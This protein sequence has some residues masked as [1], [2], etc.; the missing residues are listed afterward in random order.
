MKSIL[1][2]AIFSFALFPLGIFAQHHSALTVSVN[3]DGNT[4]TVLQ[5]LTFNNQSEDTISNIILNDWNNAYSDKNS[6]L[7]KRFSDEFVRNFQ[8]ASEKERGNTDY[9]TMVDENGGS[10]QWNRLPNQIDLIELHLINPIFPGEKKLFR[11]SYVVKVPSDV[12]TKYGHDNNGKL[13]LKDW[14]LT[15]ARYE[16]HAFV[17]YSNANLDDIANGISDYDLALTISS[18]AVA[19]S[20]LDEGTIDK[21]GSETTYRFT[22][23]NRVDFSLFIDLKPEFETY[24]NSLV[25]VVTDLKDNKLNGIQKAIIIDNVVKF[26]NQYLGDYPYQKITIS[27]TDY[28]RNPFYGLNQLPSFISPFKNDFLYEL[29]FLKTYTNNYLKSSLHLDPRKDNWIYDAVQMYVMTK[30]IEENNPDSKMMGSLSKW[31]ILKSYHLI[32]LEFNDQYSYYYM[33]MARKN[34]DQPLGDSKEKLI[35]FNEK[36]ASKYRAGLSLKYLDH[37]LNDSIVPKTIRE[38]QVMNSGKQTN[39]ADFETLLQS[40]SPKNIDWFF[41]TIIDSRDIIDYKFGTVTK[42]DDSITFNIKNRTGTTVPI[43]VYGIKNNQIVFKKWFENVRTDSTFTVDR[44]NADKIVLNYKNEVPEFNLRNNW[45]SLKVLLG[46][47]RPYK[48]A[49]LKDLEDPRYNQIMYVPTIAYNFYDGFTPGIRLSNKSLLDKPFTFDVNPAYSIKTKSLSGSL[50]FGINQYRRDSRLFNIRYGASGSYFHYAPDASYL[51]INPSVTLL[52]REKDFRDN[53]RQ[54]VSFRYNMV[55]KENSKIVIDSTENYSV[56]SARYFSNRTE[57]TN[58]VNYNT[59]LQFSKV[60]GKASGEISYRKL[61]NNNRQVNIRFYAGMFLYSKTDSD[62][63]NFGVDKPNDYMFD[64]NFF[65][66]SEKSGLLSQQ[67]I[68]GEGGFKSKLLP[69]SANQWIATTNVSFNI[70][71]W[72]E[73]YGDA[74]FVK[75]HTSDAKFLYDSGIRLNLVTDYFELYFPVY[76][77]NGWEVGQPKYQEK[78]RFIF[79]FSP[80]SLLNLFTRKWF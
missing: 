5:E 4:L 52:F 71:N 70:W 22:G 26:V 8:L 17:K 1:K 40:K 56:F 43:P 3:P 18:K 38:F 67:L 45:R 41:N 47:D 75:N 29:K 76:S 23:K 15:P 42:T 24:K 72:I 60:F 69:S 28:E 6:L 74:G 78:I 44:N 77:S 35:R 16:N 55:R 79:T 32:N 34:L 10:L 12:F 62:F 27:Q 9:I 63:Y 25:E 61:F 53:R 68:L 37:F 13:T 54:G 33:L 58:H 21:K 57:V 2:L 7:G 80:K 48:F 64:Y 19:N 11:M 39:R 30:Y 66:R 65:G 36:I 46:N 50:G 14:Y 20:D 51:K 73:V 49:F 31:K 59:D